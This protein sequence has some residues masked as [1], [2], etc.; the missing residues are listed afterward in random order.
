MLS[1]ASTFSSFSSNKIDE[2][3][4]FYR[5]VLGLE[6]EPQMGGFGLRLPGGGAAFVYP[7]DDHQAATFT[8]L[9]FEVDDIDE[10]VDSLNAQ[11]VKTKIY[12]GGDGAPPTDEKGIVRGGPD[13]GPDIAWFL[14]PAGNVLSVVDTGARRPDAG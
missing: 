14:D 2:S 1:A 4:A 3:M 6:V 5:D 8:V 10:A 7:K 12:D 11:G 13:T 9:N